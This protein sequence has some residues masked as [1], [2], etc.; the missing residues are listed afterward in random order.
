[1]KIALFIFFITTVLLTFQSC[2]TPS[3]KK[4]EH[5]NENKNYF[6]NVQYK[7]NKELD[8]NKINCIIVDKIKSTTNMEFPNLNKEK[9]IRQAVYGVLSTKNY[10][11]IELPIVDNV[12]KN[13]KN[14]SNKDLL[15]KLNVMQFY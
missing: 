2:K 9:I 11:D 6:S 3:Y 13:N 15:E 10:Q 12:L 7:I 14:I 4:V 1:M 5:F 8:V